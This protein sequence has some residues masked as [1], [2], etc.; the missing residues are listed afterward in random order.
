[1]GR[2]STK[3]SPAT[4]AAPSFDTVG[5][6]ILPGVS[7][8]EWAEPR[9]DPEAMTAPELIADAGP[10]SQDMAVEAV[11][12]PP[13]TPDWAATSGPLQVPAQGAAPA[14]QHAPE[15]AFA[16]A[17]AAMVGAAAGTVEAPP[18]YGQPPTAYG[19]APTGYG[20]P[21]T[22]YGPPA[23]ASTPAAPAYMPEPSRYPAAPTAGLVAPA[24]APSS[25]VA[26][27]ATHLAPPAPRL[28]ADTAMQSPSAPVQAMPADPS[29]VAAHGGPVAATGYGQSLEAGGPS[30]ADAGLA[31]PPARPGTPPAPDAPTALAVNQESVPPSQ[32][33][34]S[35]ERES[36]SPQHIALLSWW[37][38]M[39]A[40]GQFP[41]PASAAGPDGTAPAE[42]ADGGRKRGFPV[43]AAALSLVAVAALGAAAV[44]GSVLN[45]GI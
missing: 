37:A 23:P 33:F 30:V 22:G 31:P 38:D 36:L 3:S 35:Q 7:L 32:A 34:S 1:M 14:P 39:M 20:P 8:P 10:V 41:A 18:A 25:A 24:A 42:S 13:A 26:A 17:G 12:E 9:E 27:P 6:T 5:V 2:R 16:M 11:P 45:L 44:A 28:P 19:Q 15:P 4:G 40:A 21:P 29:D 43:K